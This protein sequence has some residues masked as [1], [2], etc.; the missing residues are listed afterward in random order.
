[1]KFSFFFC[2]DFFSFYIDLNKSFRFLSKVAKSSGQ[3]FDRQATQTRKKKTFMHFRDLLAFCRTPFLIL[4][5]FFFFFCDLPEVLCL[6][7]YIQVW[8]VFSVVLIC[9]RSKKNGK[10]SSQHKSTHTTTIKKKPIKLTSGLFLEDALHVC[11]LFLFFFFSLYFLLFCS[12]FFFD[13][14]LFFFW[15]ER[16]LTLAHILEYVDCFLS[17]LYVTYWLYSWV[18]FFIW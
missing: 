17:F 9:F 3:D 15:P 12:N 6:C 18:F 2:I 7:T 11:W 8:R 14:F 16:T 13:G 4:A 1:M 5:S 10:K